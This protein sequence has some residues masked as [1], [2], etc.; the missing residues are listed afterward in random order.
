MLRRVVLLA[1]LST[2]ARA[3][4]AHHF[5]GFETGDDVEIA[6]EAFRAAFGLAYSPWNIRN[7][8]VSQAL[9]APL[10]ALAHALG[11]SDPFALAEVAR[12]PFILLGGVNVVLSYFVARAWFDERAGLV[13]AAL[14]SIHWIPLAFGS[15]LYPRVPGT[16]FLLLAVLAATRS[17]FFT[18]G[19]LASLAFTMRYSEIVFLFPLLFLARRQAPR[20]LLGF[21]SGTLLFVG[22]Y[23]WI[24]WGR[25]FAS[26]IAFARY[27]L[28][29]RESSSL[30]REQPGWWYLATLPQWLAPP[31]WPLLWRERNKA[32]AFIAAPVLALSVVHHKE[33]RYLQAVIPFAM[34]LAAAGALAWWNARRKLVVAL[35]IIALPLQLARIRSVEKRTMAAVDAARFLRGKSVAVSQEWAYG[36][37]LFVQPHEVG[38]PPDPARLRVAA[39]RS[40]CAAM[41]ASQITPEM[42]QIVAQAGMTAAR[43][44]ERARS[45][46]VEVF[47]R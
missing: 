29:S 22:V 46:P 27:T 15:S 39:S 25:P 26:L 33:L 2:L 30:M 17:R 11:V 3:W 31:L 34:I 35:L 1:V 18:A 12:Y 9:V 14:Y 24:S 38:I 19:V 41:F 42:R 28:L 13:A 36:G 43:T 8:F 10:L 32:L 7:L 5:Y 6:Q 40:D 44:F 21:A 23:D 20:L 47:C 45:R 37:R 4:L 16:T